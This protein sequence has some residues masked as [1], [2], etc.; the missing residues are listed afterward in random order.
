MAQDPKTQGPAGAAVCEA[1]AS[2]YGFLDVE[3]APMGPST[4]RNR[5]C[6]S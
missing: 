6:I 5:S 3:E 2:G 4:S 1:S